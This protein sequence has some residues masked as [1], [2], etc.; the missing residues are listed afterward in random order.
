MKFDVD[1]IIYSDIYTIQKVRK[2]FRTWRI[3]EKQVN[4]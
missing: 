1:N 2:A 4:T 3:F